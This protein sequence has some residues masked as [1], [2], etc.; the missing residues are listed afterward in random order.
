MRDLRYVKG[1][2]F[3]FVLIFYTCCMTFG[4]VQSAVD[5]AKLQAL[6]QQSLMDQNYSQAYKYYSKE[7]S[8]REKLNDQY[9]VARANIRAAI[10]LQLNEKFNKST[11]HLENALNYGLETDNEEI[12]TDCYRLLSRAYIN[13]G[14]SIKAHEYHKNYLNLSKLDEN[15]ELS[16]SL[17][18]SQEEML[19]ILNSL[20]KTEDS[21]KEVHQNLVET[22]TIAES[23]KKKVKLLTHEKQLQEVELEKNELALQNQELELKNRKHLLYF[24]GGALLFMIVV[25]VMLVSANKRKQRDKAVIQ[26]QKEKILDS[27]NYAHKIQG[28]MLPEVELM[29]KSIPE[30]F[31]LN[32]PVSIVSGDFYFFNNEAQEGVVYLA[33]VDCTGHGVPGALMSMIG[34]NSLNQVILSGEKEVDQILNKLHNNIVRALKQDVTQN[35]DGMD[36]ALCKVDLKNSTIEFSGARNPL[37]LIQD[38]KA[39]VIKADRRPIGGVRKK[40]FKPFTKKVVKV[41]KPST[42]YMFSDGFTDQMGGK[43]NE[44]YYTKRLVS[45]LEKLEQNPVDDQLAALDKEFDQWKGS[46]KQMDDVCIMGF[47]MEGLNS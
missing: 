10:A 32:R 2:T 44:K 11:K 24:A 3:L 15:A 17:A 41:E 39:E 21:L 14:D 40:E 30:L 38:G 1:I 4:K 45:L 46:R 7:I 23:R 20:Q 37:V 26:D 13:V 29:R 28:A 16:D 31:V 22:K 34:Y 43:D 27:I 19:D 6:A 9:G 8:L 47:R 25:L 35:R 5:A 33:V 36:L 42:F 18:E 12:I